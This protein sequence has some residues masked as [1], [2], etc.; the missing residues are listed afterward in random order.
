MSEADAQFLGRMPLFS[1]FS[2][3]ELVL[4]STRFETAK[5]K[6]GEVLFCEEDTG[7]YLYVV[8]SG[9]VKVSRVLPSGKEMLL[10]FHE[11]GDYFGELSLIDGGTTP[12]TVTAVIPTTILAIGGRDFL[13]LSRNAKIKDALL[14]SLCRQLREAWSQIEILNFHNAN[15]RVRTVLYQLGEKKG[16]E[17]FEGLMI[18]MRLTHRQLA[19]LTGISRET[20]TRVLSQLQVDGLVTMQGRNIVLRNPQDLIEMAPV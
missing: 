3:D 6:R 15:A 13:Q 7:D 19:D 18:R 17:T 14:L 5:F 16:V 2:D 20:A 9:R 1:E 11:E 4:M 12:A 8:R 10:A